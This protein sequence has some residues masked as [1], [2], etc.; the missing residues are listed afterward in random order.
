MQAM[1]QP[2]IKR[3]NQSPLRV[4]V[5][6][7]GCLFGLVM[8]GLGAAMGLLGAIF[9]A[10]TLLGFDLTATALND[11]S[12]VMAATEVELNDRAQNAISQSTAFA[13]DVQSTQ[14]I[15]NNDADLL[16]QT[17]TQ[18]SQNINATST[19]VVVQNVQ[20]QTEIANDYAATQAALNAN[21]TRIQLD[22]RNTQTALGV[23]NPQTQQNIVATPAGRYS[24]D[25][26]QFDGNS[27]AIWQLEGN[28][29]STED[30]L[31]VRS[32]NG[33]IVETSA[34]ILTDYNFIN[35]YTITANIIPAIAMSAD[36]WVIFSLTDDIGLAAHFRAETLTLS[37]VGLYQFTRSQL[38]NVLTTDDLTVLRRN[39]ANLTLNS[40]T[41]IRI[42]VDDRLM[43]VSIDG[44]SVL[45]TQGIPI[46]LGA[47]GIQL[48][49]EAILRAISVSDG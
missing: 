9:V 17:A 26:T 34:Q 7:W 12:I 10:P 14:A 40:Q 16:A 48:P 22:F 37:E 31:A 46:P 39:P 4:I 36:Y 13:L 47:I 44:N 38:D 30:G 18:S 15:L 27:N 49:E 35:S 41:E 8:L 45:E 29:T 24:F 3:K 32:A 11:R 5:N 33:S 21:A 2:P 20:R 25:F 1:Q 6:Q 42:I 23:E 28:W 19:A 43:T